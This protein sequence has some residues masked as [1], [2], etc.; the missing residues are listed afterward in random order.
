MALVAQTIQATES[1]T[2][3]PGH[4]STASAYT[5]PRITRQPSL[6]RINPLRSS[7]D[8]VNKLA[9]FQ[10][11]QVVQLAILAEHLTD[12]AVSFAVIPAML[13]ALHVDHAESAFQS[14]RHRDG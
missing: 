2:P 5:Q 10:S 14:V 9:H 4:A 13:G 1:L 8:P 12:T 3:A 11:R 6:S 7:D